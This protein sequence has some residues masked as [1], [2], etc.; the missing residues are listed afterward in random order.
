M[1]QVLRMVVGEVDSLTSLFDEGLVNDEV[2]FDA[3]ALEQHL[4]R[5]A[6]CPERDAAIEKLA[7]YTNQ[8]TPTQIESCASVLT[9][10]GWLEEAE[11]LKHLTG[12]GA[13]QMSIMLL[14]QLDDAQLALLNIKRRLNKK[15][16]E[17]NLEKCID[18]VEW[19]TEVFMSA[20][21]FTQSMTEAYEFLPRLQERDPELYNTLGVLYTLICE[22]DYQKEPY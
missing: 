4:Y 7:K 10:S 16:V 22:D 14:S 5:F 8:L 21:E 9:V 15:D 19:E 17:V 3:L 12:D 18:M 20:L 2:V 6:A 13:A 11:M 1:N